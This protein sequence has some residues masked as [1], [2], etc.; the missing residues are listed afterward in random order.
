MFKKL[1]VMLSIMSLSA[2]V[3]YYPHTRY[4]KNEPVYRPSYD[5]PFEPKL[6]RKHQQ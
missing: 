3:A 1:I 5:P 6:D 2:C 4:E